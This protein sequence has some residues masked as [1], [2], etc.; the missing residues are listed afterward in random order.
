VNILTREKQIEAIGALVEGVSVRAT[1]RL[2]GVADHE[3]ICRPRR[4][5]Y[6]PDAALGNLRP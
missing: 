6:F 4:T 2:T 3:A 5:R 1:E